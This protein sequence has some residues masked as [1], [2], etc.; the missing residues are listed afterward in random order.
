[1]LRGTLIKSVWRGDEN[2]EQLC[3]EHPLEQAA[4]F[5]VVQRMCPGDR[6]LTTVLA[7]ACCFD[8]ELP[9][10]SENARKLCALWCNARG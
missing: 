7:N 1:M 6:A 8:C 2:E 10:A 9:A 3:I 4:F 5:V